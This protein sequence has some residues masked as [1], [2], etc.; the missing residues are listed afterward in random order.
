M[1]QP[2]DTNLE[3]MPP[4][5]LFA[6]VKAEAMTAIRNASYKAADA[7]LIELRRRSETII[8]TLTAAAS[9]YLN[10]KMK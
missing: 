3:I 2:P 5:T 7:A 9:G 1:K 6:N 8:E 4:P 10:R